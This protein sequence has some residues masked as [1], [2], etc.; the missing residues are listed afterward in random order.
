MDG[1]GALELAHHRPAGGGDHRL[2][3][4]R[5]ERLRDFDRAALDAARL[6]PR[7]H[8]EHGRGA[9]S[10]RPRRGASFGGGGHESKTK[11]MR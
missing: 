11:M 2:P 10:R 5:G 6:E 9:G 7:Q 4:G 3:P 8:L 1:A